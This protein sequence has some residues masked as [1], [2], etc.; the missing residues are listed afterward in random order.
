MW[1]G[2]CKQK[3]NTKFLWGNLLE[4]S[5]LDDQEDG[6]IIIGYFL[7]K[8][9]E[10]VKWMD[11]AQSHALWRDLVFSAFNFRVILSQICLGCVGAPHQ[12]QCRVA[13]NQMQG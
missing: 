11:L 8:L 1:L 6:D 12:L 13:T 2:L 10:D 9:P 3:V 4:R 7:G 5:H